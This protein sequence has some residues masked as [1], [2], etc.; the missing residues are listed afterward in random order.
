MHSI[1]FSCFGVAT[2]TTACIARYL[3]ENVGYM[4]VFVG[5]GAFNLVALMALLIWFKEESVDYGDVD[6]QI[7]SNDDGGPHQN[8]K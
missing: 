7:G 5:L 6:T 3:L 1:T 4:A 2:L 8:G